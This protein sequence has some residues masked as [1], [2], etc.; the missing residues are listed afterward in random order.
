MT[1][2]KITA[3]LAGPVADYAPRLDGL[4]VEVAFHRERRPKS[5]VPRRCD[6][7]PDPMRCPEIPVARE[8]IGG[9]PVFRASD[10]IARRSAPHV[11]HFGKR[12]GVERAGLLH[13]S[14]RKVVVTSNTWTKSYRLPVN[15]LTPDRV[16]WFALGD[17]VRLRD[18]LRDVAQ[19]GRKVAHGW[20]RVKRWRVEDSA[21]DYSWYAPGGDGRPVL[22]RSLPLCPAL[23]ADLDGWRAGYD[24]CCPPYWHSDRYTEV[25]KPC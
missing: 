9:W 8:E 15:V 6:P 16:V 18:L 2:L 1:P 11:A 23:P 21:A 24:S 19:I 3:E 4:L 7:A 5:E 25:V 17:A 12:I 20:G 10:P 22:M 14:E 13:P